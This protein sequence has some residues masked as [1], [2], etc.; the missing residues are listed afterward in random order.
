LSECF[1]EN[2]NTRRC[3]IIEVT[4]AEDFSRLLRLGRFA[5]RKEHRAERIEHRAKRKATD[6]FPHDFSAFLLLTAHRLLLT[7]IL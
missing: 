1:E 6:F 3:A 5:K 4:N 2:G 7:V